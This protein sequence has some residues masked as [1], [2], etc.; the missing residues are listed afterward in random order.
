M[1]TISGNTININGQRRPNLFMTYPK[2]IFPKRLPMH[3]KDATYEASSI[4]IGPVGNGD[5]S[6]VKRII[7]GLLHPSKI[8]NPIVAKFTVKV[9]SLE[10][11]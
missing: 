3:C 7:D 6:E 5:S 9:K 8:P 4:E 11:F 10:M 2:I 1:L